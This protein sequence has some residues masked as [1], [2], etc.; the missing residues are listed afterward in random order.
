[1]SREPRSDEL[2][3]CELLPCPFCGGM[4]EVRQVGNDHTKKRAAHVVCKTFGCQIEI[5]VATLLHPGHEW[6]EA[7]AIELWNTRA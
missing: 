1:M 6:C 5:R 2:D 7:K 4:P 3:G